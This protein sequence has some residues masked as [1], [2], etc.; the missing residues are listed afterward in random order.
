MGVI[1]YL[2]DVTGNVVAQHLHELGT[3]LVDPG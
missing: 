3:G 1:A 2:N